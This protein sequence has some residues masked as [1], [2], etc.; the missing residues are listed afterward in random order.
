MKESPYLLDRNL[1]GLI[2]LINDYERISS[3]MMVRV[4]SNYH[5]MKK[6]ADILEKKGLIERHVDTE[7]KNRILL[8]STP[9]ILAIAELLKRAEI[10]LEKFLDERRCRCL[11]APLYKISN[12][13]R[14]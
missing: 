1:I 5:Y 11:T 6:T 4:N 7:R 10:E 2:M 9:E 13:P 12:W 8:E 3:S 14:I